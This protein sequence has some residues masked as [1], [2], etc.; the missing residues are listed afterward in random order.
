MSSPQLNKLAQALADVRV[1]TPTR[2][3]VLVRVTGMILAAR[4]IKAPLG[5]CCEV[6]AEDGAPVACEVVGLQGGEV[7][8][9]PFGGI[10]GL[11]PGA[12]VGLV[13]T[14]ARSQA[15]VAASA[16]A[17]LAAKTDQG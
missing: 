16:V 12:P 4:G 9:M 15:S 6:V 7:M 3:G 2:R 11:R 17:L 10:A 14:K 1:G 13:S 5:A 8:L